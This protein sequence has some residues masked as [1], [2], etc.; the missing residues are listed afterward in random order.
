MKRSY[1]LKCNRNAS[2]SIVN[3]STVISYMCKNST[4]HI[5]LTD[6]R[7][8]KNLSV[9]AIEILTIRNALKMIIQE[10]HP[11]TIIKSDWLIAIQ[12]IKIYS[13]PS[14]QFCYLVEDYHY[15]D[16]NN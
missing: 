2:K 15:V 9:F 10:K 14:N 6:G 11:N 4:G 13:K 5:I 12:A 3:Q 7:K 8:I 16:K 1:C